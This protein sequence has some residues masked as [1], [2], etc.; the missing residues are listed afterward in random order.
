MI[1]FFAL[2]IRLEIKSKKRP[3]ERIK[4]MKC[5]E[6]IL[7]SIKKC[8]FFSSDAKLPKVNDAFLFDGIES[9]K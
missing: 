9:R 1:Y 4:E 3:K 6:K 7:I 2:S 5:E 8:H